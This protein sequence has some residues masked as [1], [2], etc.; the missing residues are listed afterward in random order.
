MARNQRRVAP[1]QAQFVAKAVYGRQNKRNAE[2]YAAL[3]T[4][5]VEEFA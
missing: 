5:L 1:K 4:A 3:L 2:Q